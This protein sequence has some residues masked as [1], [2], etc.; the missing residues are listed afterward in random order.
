MLPGGCTISRIHRP[1]QPSALV[2]LQV[3]AGSLPDA[4]ARQIVKTA[5]EHLE[6]DDVEDWILHVWGTTKG[7][8]VEQAKALIHQLVRDYVAGG[9]IA[10]VQVSL[11]ARCTPLVYPSVLWAVGAGLFDSP[12]NAAGIQRS[13]AAEEPDVLRKACAGIPCQASGKNRGPTLPSA[14]VDKEHRPR[15]STRITCASVW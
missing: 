1:P 2:S 15:I 6:R 8:T 9:H 11:G 7:R 12:S 5:M 13:L 14:N 3:C 10:D 4:S